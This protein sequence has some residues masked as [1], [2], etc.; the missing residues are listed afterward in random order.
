MAEETK[1]LI[2]KLTSTTFIELFDQL[3]DDYKD[4][5][6]KLLLQ[7]DVEAKASLPLLNKFGE[8]CDK[9]GKEYKL[10]QN[11]W[12]TWDLINDRGY[13]DEC[14]FDAEIVQYAKIIKQLGNVPK[15][16]FARLEIIN[17]YQIQVHYMSYEKWE[18]YQ[19]EQDDI[20]GDPYN[21]HVDKKIENYVKTD[22][23]NI[24]TYI[25]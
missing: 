25:F 11:S 3:N 19:K 22:I 2:P 21:F 17:N 14:D 4:E 18:E 9:L 16:S 13:T 15:D 20:G 7:K 10:R 8:K 6:M 24:I 12:H 23:I 1:K 5:I